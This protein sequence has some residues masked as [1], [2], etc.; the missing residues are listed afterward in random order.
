[1]QDI[2]IDKDGKLRCSNCGGTN[3]QTKRTRRAKVVGV[4]AGVATVGLAGA[5]A[6]LLAKQKLYCQACGTYNKMGNAQPLRSK[7]SAP[8]LPPSPPK[9]KASEG[10]EQIGMALIGAIAIG[11]FFWAIFAGSIGWAIISGLVS[12]LF[13]A[14]LIA[15]LKGLGKAP[16][17][18]VRS[19][20]PPNAPTRN[21]LSGAQKAQ[22]ITDPSVPAKLTVKGTGPRPPRNEAERKPGSPV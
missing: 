20:K 13:I 9:K 17:Q 5:A 12:L 4:T 11:V 21:I 15:D 14:A 22:G 7:E 16:A 3:F 1:M 19:S 8:K 2:Q 6:P 10:E 18:K